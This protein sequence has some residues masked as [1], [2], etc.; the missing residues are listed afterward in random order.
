MD[1]SLND[2]QQLIQDSAKDFVQGSCERDVLLK[3]D[4][5]PLTIMDKHWQQ[6][7]EMGWAG[8]AIPEEFGGSGNSLTDVAVLF[9]ELG[10]GPVPGPLFTSAVLCARIIMA[11]GSAAQ[12]QAL[13]PGIASG[14]RI[15]SLAYTEVQYGWSPERIKMKAKK[16]GSDYVLSGTKLFIEDAQYATDLLVVAGVEGGAGLSVFRVDAKA[17][18]VSV[19]PLTGFM[20]GQAEVILK[21]VKVAAADAML[22]TGDQ[23][24]RALLQAAPILC[25]YKVGG[26]KRAY[27]MSLA[28]AGER[29]QFN[30]V[31]GRFPRVQDHLINAVNALDSARWTTYEAL[32]KLDNNMEDA[33]GSVHV[34]KAVASESYVR[35][36]DM[37]HEVHA[38]IGVLR[39]Y[40][41]TLHTKMSRS[42]YH[43]LGSPREHHR[44]LERALKLVA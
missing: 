13:L 10:T 5:G 3:F 30:T 2:T 44:L 21:D 43:T 6:M 9:E 31:I 33:A 23:L 12:K 35:A 11:A 22:D 25:A 7:S 38:G 42:L 41:L 24:A 18:G 4:R 34:A 27:E 1:L 14:K 15:F 29:K 16:S 36:T 37:A 8:M 20:V 26:C 40:G 32:W 17:A 19:R 39:E 28:Y